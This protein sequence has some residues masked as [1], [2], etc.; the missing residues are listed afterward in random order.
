ML[1]LAGLA[2]Q[3]PNPE[4]WQ[5]LID[6]DVESRYAIM[7]T[8]IIQKY[9]FSKVKFKDVK[10]YTKCYVP[11][12]LRENEKVKNFC[13]SFWKIREHQM[14]P[15][16]NQTL[17]ECRIVTGDTDVYVRQSESTAE[18]D[19]EKYYADFLRTKAKAKGLE[20]FV[21]PNTKK[22]LI[23]NSDSGRTSMSTCSKYDSFN[24]EVGVG[25]AWAKYCGHDISGNEY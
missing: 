12:V 15:E 22:V 11:T 19:A 9:R 18:F 3:C 20:V 13:I 5:K 6:E 7:T 10:P 25:L 2:D 4:W 16:N 8:G 23:V 24:Y 1:F 14:V 21:V 17:V